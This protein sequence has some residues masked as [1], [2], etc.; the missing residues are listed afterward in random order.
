MR[1]ISQAAF[2]KLM[3]GI[4]L[5]EGFIGEFKDSE[6]EFVTPKP[7]V[8]VVSKTN[9]VEL[10]FDQ[11]G[12]GHT[13]FRIDSDKGWQS[14][15]RLGVEDSFYWLPRFEGDTKEDLNNI[16]AVQLERIEERR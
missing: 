7:L 12:C 1:S 6:Y 14:L 13:K 2:K 5:P 10:L 9:D 16:V 3:Q 11:N 4:T 15:D 8:Y